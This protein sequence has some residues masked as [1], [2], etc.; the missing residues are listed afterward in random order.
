MTVA[1][2]SASS[3]TP[4]WKLGQGKS[5]T[6]W[7]NQ[8]AKRGWTPKQI[9]EALQGGKS[10]PAKNMVNQGNGATRYV[11]PKTGRSVVIDNVTKEII[12]VGGDGFKY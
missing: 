3:N 8:M 10:F 1:S 12:H 11:H 5:A 4:K 2:M 6:K 9:G 7:A